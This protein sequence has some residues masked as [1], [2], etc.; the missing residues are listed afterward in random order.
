[1][2]KNMKIILIIALSLITCLISAFFLFR[3]FFGEEGRDFIGGES[4]SINPDTILE[5]LSQGKT[6]V[7]IP[8]EYMPDEKSRE[9]VEW[10]SADYDLIVEALHEMMWGETLEGWKMNLMGFE[11][12]CEYIDKGPR[13]ANYTYFKV[14]KLRERKSRFVS[15]L[16]VS[17]N[18]NSVRASMWEN[19]PRLC[20]WDEINPEKLE[21]SAEE[22]LDIA[23]KNGGAEY[24]VSI[25]NS[26]KIIVSLP[27]KLD[28][29]GWIVSY[30][31]LHTF[32]KYY[33][34]AKT[35][36]VVAH[37]EP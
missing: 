30:R 29:D 26:C 20:C 13:N 3:Y 1:M 16:W 22:A 25:E 8:Q 28:Y 34:D 32:N 19:Y 37:K 23:E 9:Y 12:D 11:W 27:A 6:D 14:E 15:N 21:I 10:K 31:Y 35:G 18:W 33:I 7:F 36:E 17:P 4:Y 24:R 2:S 5:D